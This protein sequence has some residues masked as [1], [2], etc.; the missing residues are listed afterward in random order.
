MIR[1][2]LIVDDKKDLDQTLI[3]TSPVSLVEASTS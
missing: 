1:T 3:A 2:F